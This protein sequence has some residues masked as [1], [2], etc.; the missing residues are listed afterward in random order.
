MRRLL[1][2]AALSTAIVFPAAAQEQ[3]VWQSLAPFPAPTRE[4]AL[5]AAENKVY[6]F[7]GQ[8]LGYVPLGLVYQYDPAANT[9]A[10]KKRM[11]LPSHHNAMVEY[12]GKIYFFGGFKLPETGQFGW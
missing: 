11:P 2:V 12:Q 3:S 8:A 9:W 1:I 4:A 10:E 7:T 6:M 5:I